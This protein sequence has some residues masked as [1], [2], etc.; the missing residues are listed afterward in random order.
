VA[1]KLSNAKICKDQICYKTSFLLVKD[2]KENIILGTP[3]LTLL[4]PFMVNDKE[5]ITEALGRTVKFEFTH[6]PKIKDINSVKRNNISALN[7]IDLKRK[8]I[9]FINKEIHYKRIDEQLHSK[10]IQEIIRNIQDKFIKHLCSDQPNAFWKRKVHTV[11]LPYEPDFK[12]SNIP[13][14]A[15]PIHM[16]EQQLN[17]CKKE[18]QEYLDKGL[19]RHSKSPWSCSAFYV[20]NAAELERGSP[21][22]VINYR[23][24]NSALQWI[25][26]PIPN[27][28]DL[29]NRLQ[30][31]SVFSKFDLKSGY[32]QIQLKEEDKYKTGFVVPFGHFEWNVMPLGLK[33][34]P[35]EFQ[36]KMNDIFNK[37]SDFVIVYLDDILVFSDSINQH[38]DHMNKFFE[39]IRSNGLALSEKKLK[40]FQSK[41]RFLGFDISQG[42]YSPISRSLEFVTKF[43]DKI[44]DKT[45]LQRFLGCL[46]YVSDFIPNL[47]IICGPLFKRLKKNPPAWDDTMT[48]SIINL[49][50][51][52]KKLP[53]LGIPCPNAKLI[54]ETDASDLGFGGILKQVLPGSEKE[55]VVRFYS[56]TWT[57]PQLN[58][59]TIKKEIL[60]IVL[61]IM[62]FQDDLF[63]KPFVLKTDCKSAKSVLQKDVK[64][65]VSKHIFARW[66]ALLACFDFEIMHIEG[67]KNALPDFLTREFLQGKT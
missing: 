43:P 2:M 35:S 34:A 61:C 26:Y 23:P 56:G 3:F 32:Y 15:R 37:Y 18:I 7:Q 55:Q 21:R 4:Y 53:C 14:K 44:I 13:T 17:Y 39:I 54:V 46:N 12:E 42:M 27:K 60:A 19:I 63:S 48:T 11:S 45:Q 52:V 24:L 1:Y 28:R 51:I 29:I 20:V 65:L 41:I 49:K 58:Y 67:T 8:Q 16:S 36:N 25:R 6:Q 22:L 64:N 47:R 5:I 30:N 31:K 50:K 9:N 66:Q 62:K 38:I 33:N 57:G 10:K 59:S 40:I